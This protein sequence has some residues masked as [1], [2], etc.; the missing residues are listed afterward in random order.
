MHKR[1]HKIFFNWEIIEF[2]LVLLNTRFYWER[3]LVI[4][5][6]YV[7]NSLNISDNAK[8]EFLEKI[9]LQSDQK[10]WQ[11]YCRLDLSSV[12]EHLTCWLAISSLRGSFLG[13]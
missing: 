9:F 5:C 10:I 4:R 2:K 7:K 13:I 1:I 12:S 6:Q 8:T 3:I 11:K